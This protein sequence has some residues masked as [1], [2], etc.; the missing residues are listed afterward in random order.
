MFWFNNKKSKKNKISNEESDISE[1]SHQQTMI[2]KQ[3]K[4]HEI[5]VDQIDEL[6]K[7]IIMMEFEDK[8]K[9]LTQLTKDNSLFLMN[10]MSDRQ[11]APT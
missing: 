10:F 4:N 2:S 3:D 11:D 9:Y 1:I 6:M 8:K 7:H 5:Y